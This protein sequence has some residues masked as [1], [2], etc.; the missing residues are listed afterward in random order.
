[1]WCRRWLQDAVV[2][3]HLISSQQ[4]VRSE[5]EFNLFCF[6]SGSGWLW[7]RTQM[8][9]KDQIE[10]ASEHLNY[11]KR[12][13]NFSNRFSVQFGKKSQV[14]A[15]FWMLSMHFATF[16]TFGGSSKLKEK[17]IRMQMEELIKDGDRCFTLA[18]VLALLFVDYV[19]CW[20]FFLSRFKQINLNVTVDA[21][22]HSH[23]T[24]RMSCPVVECKKP[25]ELV[26][27]SILE[28][29]LLRFTQQ[30]NITI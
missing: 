18:N 27:S 2:C 21:F 10:Q 24:S 28:R 25:S 11:A 12:R 3:T 22:L 20:H 9:D 19:V 1:M 8:S 16:A 5:Q 14:I 30:W 7:G 13:L 17:L 26:D 6:L 4:W 15:G 29:W 23:M